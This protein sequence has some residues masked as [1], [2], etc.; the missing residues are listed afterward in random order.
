MTLGLMYF[1]AS[2]FTST[3]T[4]NGQAYPGLFI[5]ACLLQGVGGLVSSPLCSLFRSVRLMHRLAPE[6][7]FAPTTTD[8]HQAHIELIFALRKIKSTKQDAT[9]CS[10]KIPEDLDLMAITEDSRK[11]L[12]ALSKELSE[13]NLT[14]NFHLK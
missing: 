7:H 10:E 11:R 1:S 5:F 14:S 13:I 9:M 2:I 8:S 3:S 6:G 4:P 12:V